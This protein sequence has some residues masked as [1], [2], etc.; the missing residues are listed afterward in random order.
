M[1]V[2]EFWPL[3]L[4]KAWAKLHGSYEAAFSSQRN[5]MRAEVVAAYL[6]GGLVNSFSLPPDI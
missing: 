6:T 3:V 5:H 1:R 2:Q 4:E